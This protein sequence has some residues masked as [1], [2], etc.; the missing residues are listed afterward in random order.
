MPLVAVS[1]NKPVTHHLNTGEPHQVNT[2]QT[3]CEADWWFAV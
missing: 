2:S 1:S 3:F